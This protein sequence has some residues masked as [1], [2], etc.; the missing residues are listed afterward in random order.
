MRSRRAVIAVAQLTMFVALSAPLAACAGPARSSVRPSGAPATQVDT[1]PPTPAHAAGLFVVQ[2]HT[3][4]AI[5][6]DGQGFVLYRFDADSANPPQSRCV[7]VC[8]RDWLP[9]PATPELRV[10]GIDRQLVGQVARPD[11]SAQLTLAGWP[12]YGFAGDRAPGDATGHRHEARWFVI[13]PNGAR[14]GQPAGP[15]G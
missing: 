9:V 13:T 1:R 12:L 14:V 5:V 3:L 2:S 15:A 6:I 8:M 7:D 4:G 10:V 11:G